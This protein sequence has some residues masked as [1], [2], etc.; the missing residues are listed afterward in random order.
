MGII[1]RKQRE[2]KEMR[3][4]ILESA[5][6]IFLEKGYE[7]T[8][9]RNIAID[10]EYSTGVI[11]LHFKDKGEVFHELLKEGFR[12]LEKQLQFLEK[13]EEPFDRLKE[14]GRTFINFAKNNK[15]YYKLMFLTDESSP[16]PLPQKDFQIVKDTTEKLLALVIECQKSGRFK[17]MNAEYFLF[18]FLASIH[19]ICTVF[20][21]VQTPN[22]INKSDLELTTHGYEHLVLL[23]EKG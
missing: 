15:E 6:K 17:D 12:L 5:R 18:M 16:N 13:I 20:Y 22:F 1:D 7:N 19:G 21:K 14:S 10:I 8:T 2:K 9:I 3:E 4:R 23:L 11:Y